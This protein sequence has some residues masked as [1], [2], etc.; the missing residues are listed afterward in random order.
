MLAGR[1]PEAVR[2]YEQMVKALPNEPGARFN[3][4][5]ALDAAGRPRE[6][7]KNLEQI[8][9]TELGNHHYWFLLGIEYQK[10]QQPAQAVDPLERAVSLDL[11]NFSYRL[12]VADAYLGSGASARA[13]AAFRDLTGKRPE[14][15]KYLLGLVCSQLAMSSEAYQTLMQVAP[16]SSF[17]YALAALASFDKEDTATAAALYRR[18]LSA[19]P[20]APWLQLELSAV[21]RS[22]PVPPGD[23]NSAADAGHPRAQLFHKHDLRGV[24]ARTSG[25]KAAEPL[26]WRARACSELARDSLARMAA[27]PPSAEGHEV[28]G[29]VFKEAGR[30]ENSLAEFREAIRLAP[31]DTRLRG[32]LAKALSVRRGRHA[33]DTARRC[34][35]GA[36]GMGV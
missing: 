1:Y 20:L 31:H 7:L 22:A 8:K 27:L 10:L 15:A 5:V 30:W 3:L 36:G 26:Y 21:E 9:A 2:L 16:G 18:A 6:A 11:A 32:E 34:G 28:L 13:E 19:Q 24:L 25:A 23:A 29:Q 35:A 14:N 33:P 4:A 17:S 12:E